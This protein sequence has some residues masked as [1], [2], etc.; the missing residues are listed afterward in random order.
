MVIENG[1]VFGDGVNVASRIEALARPG[2]VAVSGAAKD[3]VGN[4][5]DVAF[6]S[7]GEPPLKNIDRAVQVFHVRQGAI[8]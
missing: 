6:D 8:R 7:A 2:G 4:R 5:L 1:D 3:Q